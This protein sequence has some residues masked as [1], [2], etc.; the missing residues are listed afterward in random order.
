[1]PD[2]PLKLL[3]KEIRMPQNIRIDENQLIQNMET[4]MTDFNRK[5]R[6]RDYLEIG[7]A[8]GVIFIFGRL[9]YNTIPWL[10]KTGAGVVVA[11]A[12]L[13]LFRILF[14]RSRKKEPPLSQDIR[15]GLLLLREKV[16]GQIRLL[17]SILY[18]Y[19]LPLYA[20]L[21]LFVT[22][23]LA[24][25]YSK[26]DIGAIVRKTNAGT[27]ILVGF[28]G[29][30]LGIL[31]L[32]VITFICYRVYRANIQAVREYLQPLKARVEQALAQLEQ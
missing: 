25:A 12:L 31:V 30:V 9:A 23:I 24:D 29:V 18:W 5:I 15:G 13:I 26:A 6:R 16:A 17:D 28:L 10:A 19:V 22:G 32:G 7:A 2:E 1:M 27:G 4:I 14:S 21:V 11:G 3:W 8:L 20:G